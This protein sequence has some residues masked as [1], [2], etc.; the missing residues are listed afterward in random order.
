MNFKSITV[1]ALMSL[2]SLAFAHVITGKTAYSALKGANEIRYT[3]Q[4]KAPS[5]ISFNSDER[6]ISGSLEQVMKAIFK[7][8]PETSF[9]LIKSTVDEIGYTHNTYQQ[10]FKEVKVE[11]ATYVS[12]EKN[13][14]I[15]S[16]SGF[17]LLLEDFSTATS[18][19]EQDGL[20]SVLNFIGA[21]TYKWQ[22]AEEEQHIK[23]IMDD[24]SASYYPKGEQVIIAN[25]AE[26]NTAD[27]RLA[28]KF[29]VYAHEPMS[30]NEYYID[31]N[32]EE[33]IFINGQIHTG[34]VTGTAITAY[35]GTQ[36]ITT[37]SVSS[38]IYRLR[39][40]ERGNGIVTLDC[41]TG[42]NY[43][44]AL[45]FTDT[46]NIWNNINA[47][48]NE[49]A[50]DAHWGAEKT[51]DY[52]WN[53]HNRN[54]IDG[55]GFALFS[56]VHYDV[57]YA[58]AF[59][60]GQRMT[61][62]DGSPTSVLNSP[63]TA[64]DIAG[65][66]IA[67]GLTSN[68]AD[69]IYQRESGALNESFSDI[70]G[71]AIEFYARPNNAD[72]LIGDDLG[73]SIRSM[74][75]PNAYGDPDT[76]GGTS[77]RNPNCGAP[78]RAN[79]YCGVHSNSGVQ[80]YW[81]YLLSEGGSG[82]NDLSNSFNVT[83]LGIDTASKIAFRNLTVY[84]SQN[85]TFAD[86]R[87]YSIRSAIDLYGACSPQVESVTNAWYAVGV[88]QPYVPGVG[89]DFV[90]TDTSSCIAPFRVKFQNTSNNAVNYTWNF[91]DG[92]SSSQNS[93][94]KTYNSIGNFDVTLIADGGACGIDTVVRLGYVS[95]DTANLCNTVMTTG[96]NTTQTSCSG[97]LYDSGGSSSDYED[98]FNGTITIAP[99]GAA[100][101][102][103]NFVNFDVEAGQGTS[104]NY[105]YM[106]I[107]DGPSV[108]SPSL[109]IFCNNNIPGNIT[110][111]KSAITIRFISDVNT[112]GA[113]FEIDWTCMMPI[114][115]PS[116]NFFVSTDT[117]CSGIVQ[118]FDYSANGP[119]SW[120]WDFGDG[121]R[122]TSQNPNKVYTSNGVFNVKLVTSN[123]FG[124]DSLIQNNYVSVRRPRVTGF[125]GDT[126]CPN[127]AAVLSVNGSGDVNWYDAASG[128]NLVGSGNPFTAPMVTNTTTYY[129]EA[130]DKSGVISAGAASNTIGGGNSFNGD[131]HL[132]FSA[133][134]DFNLKSVLVYAGSAGNRTI[135]LRNSN[136]AILQS[137]VVNI[138]SGAQRVILDFDIPVGVDYQL[139]VALGSSPDLF[140]N[141][142]GVQYPYNN[143]VVNITASSAQSVPLDFYYFF[144]NW[145]VQEVCKFSR[146]PVTAIFDP[147]CTLTSIEDK[148]QSVSINLVPNPT[149][150]Q[151]AINLELLNSTQANL[152]I[153]NIN[154]QTVKEINTGL[155]PNG[156]S[157]FNVNVSE[158]TQGIYFVNFRSDVMN[159][160]TKLIIMD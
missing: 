9:K 155:L 79:D 88:G 48:K 70:F 95:V 78:T 103:L 31:A 81:F 4:S 58:N 18:V 130:F 13:G 43:G 133:L 123:G 7:D 63:L 51:W 111:T 104:C 2:S 36:T 125:N 11:H 30:R 143:G 136:G 75:N 73:N 144:Y 50:T 90:S 147:N 47:A 145:E 108:N 59:W 22:V 154:G 127:K 96:T 84:L 64:L 93:P 97:K 142:T 72:W 120:S 38:S 160:V 113:G 118:F 89:A 149:K 21:A 1:A 15:E 140:R 10:F 152:T 19:A 124:V 137:R 16:I 32:T 41:N 159:K 82:V 39:N 150:D 12:H 35:S 131:Q 109:G 23:M 24:P 107:F 56:Y 46:D 100:S 5:F 98:N 116:T 156:T 68:T 86:A 3:E 122:S 99:Q 61:Y 33:I 129:A 57:N 65:H 62:G 105:D 112:T 6:P 94:L 91:G 44:A 40:T 115:A 138:P 49:Y 132:I 55:N 126:A 128:G 117:T 74:V 20:T 153:S 106:E 77:W 102:T 83:G 134:K 101:V 27:Y 53:V 139:G 76:Y 71:T 92:T 119:S 85:S 45:D 26:Y 148:S 52:F 151:V 158:L 54:S 42:T 34:N 80:N 37:D 60:D 28:W 69:L 114:S 110:S 29:N 14:F 25:K 141:N 121:T 66:E 135:Q 146:V 67:H 87:F 157:T 8:S 17:G